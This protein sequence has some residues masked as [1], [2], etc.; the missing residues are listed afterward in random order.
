MG[1]FYKMYRSDVFVYSD[2][3]QFSKRNFQNYNFIKTPD[4][5]KQRITL[6]ITYH[7][8]PINEIEIAA[9][10]KDI[11]NLIRTIWFCYHKSPFYKLI[12]GGIEAILTA[13]HKSLADMNICLTEHMA[14]SF[15]ITTKRYLSSELGIQKH[16]D[17]RIVEIC[18]IFGAD[19]YF[20]GTG[21]VEYHNPELYTAHGIKLIYTDYTPITYPQGKAPFIPCLSSLDYVMSCGYNIPEEWKSKRTVI[22]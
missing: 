13:E 17:E 3:V 11:E 12:W 22:V 8:D 7:A 18:E 16:K 5:R 2:D 14:A 9:T 10:K 19:V 21:A 6:P 20:S 15:G 1:Y 4:G